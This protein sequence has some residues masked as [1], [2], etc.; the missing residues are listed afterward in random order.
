[1]SWPQRTQ[2][3]QEYKYVKMYVYYGEIFKAML[4]R[5]NKKVINFRIY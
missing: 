3:Q 1:M 4:G 2:T 5:L